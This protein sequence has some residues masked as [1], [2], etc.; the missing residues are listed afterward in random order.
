MGLFEE[1]DKCGKLSK[2]NKFDKLDDEVANQPAREF[3][4]A[5]LPT[6]LPERAHVLGVFTLT[7]CYSRQG[8]LCTRT[9]S[10]EM[11]RYSRLVS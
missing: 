9:T 1:V 10:V 5:K 4:A 7:A 8:I 2:S 6:I 11:P 3:V